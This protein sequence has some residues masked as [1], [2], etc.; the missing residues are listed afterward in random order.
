MKKLMQ[1]R[2]PLTTASYLHVIFDH[3]GI[4]VVALLI[5]HVDLLVQLFAKILQAEFRWNEVV[6]VPTWHNL[7]EGLLKC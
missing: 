1:V 5:R 3:F 6:V 7:V 4:N 2:R